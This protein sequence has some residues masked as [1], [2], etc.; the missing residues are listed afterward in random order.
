VG[1]MPN[2][3]AMDVA[4]AHDMQNG[5]GD[6]MPRKHLMMFL[7]FTFVNCPLCIIFLCFFFGVMMALCE[8]WPIWTG[9]IYVAGTVCG[10]GNPLTDVVPEDHLGRFIDLVTA[11]W[12]IAVTGTIIG[13]AAGLKIVNDFAQLL[14]RS[15]YHAATFVFYSFVTIPV[16][17]FLLCLVFGGVLALV[18]DWSFTTGFLYV[19]SDLAALGNP[20]TSA[21]PTSGFGTLLDIVVATWCLTFGSTVMGLVGSLVFTEKLLERVEGFQCG[22]SRKKVQPISI[23]PESGESVADSNGNPDCAQQ[24]AEAKVET[25][26]EAKEEAEEGREEEE[27]ARPSI[28]TFLF[29]VLVLVPTAVAI[30]SLIAALILSSVEDPVVTI[31]SVLVPDNNATN[32]TA[33][34]TGTNTNTT[35]GTAG[36]GADRLLR[37]AFKRDYVTLDEWTL[38]QS[39]LY[40]TGNICGLGTPLSNLSPTST[41]G[42]A[43][44]LLVAFFS[45]ALGGLF[46][47]GWW[48]SWST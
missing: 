46:S 41:L 44:D 10:L 32:A 15:K 37:A 9:F 47:S 8:G 7:Q 4:M 6:K 23:Q 43:I 29:T 1:T 18:E 2:D 42:I 26:V 35:A 40:V 25:Q 48:R 13:I 27:E 39:F 31:E 3:V 17:C 33:T 28:C 16:A 30:C 21:S 45:L 19:A 12:A 34:A 20:L 36:A 38:W 11:F 22:S 5:G 24:A 14:N